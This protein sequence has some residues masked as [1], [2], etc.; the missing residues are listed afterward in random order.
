[1]GGEGMTSP[2]F[3]SISPGTHPASPAANEVTLISSLIKCSQLARANQQEEKSLPFSHCGWWH[4]YRFQGERDARP[5]LAL[6]NSDF[7]AESPKG[8]P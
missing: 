1:M 5:R 6:G 4:R 2:G 3:G 8:T 7:R